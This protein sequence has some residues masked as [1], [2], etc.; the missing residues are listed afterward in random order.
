MAEETCPPSGHKKPAMLEGKLFACIIYICMHR[1]TMCYNYIDYPKKQ[2]LAEETCPPSI[3]LITRDQHSKSIVVNREAIKLLHTITKPVAVLGICG[4][5]R[6]GKSYFLSRVLGGDDFTVT[7][8][9]DPCTRGIWMS[10]NVL[11]FDDHVLILLDTE[12]MGAAQ[13]SESSSREDV[14]GILV[15]IILLSS[16][17]IY[18]TKGVIRESDI[19]QMRYKHNYTYANQVVIDLRIYYASVCAC[20][21]EVYGSV[22]VWCVGCSGIKESSFHL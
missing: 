8:S 16:C 11:E 3:P 19:Q 20:A 7:H 5:Y 15:L 18:N 1:L 17:L 9:R 21:S 4:P 10:T 22:C 13:A 14:M 12:G 2:K 6:T